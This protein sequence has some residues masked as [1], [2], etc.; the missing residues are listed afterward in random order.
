M[1]HD[2][3]AVTG[4]AGIVGT[5]V[6]QQLLRAGHTVHALVR[7][8]PPDGHPLLT[9]NVTLTMLDLATASEESMVNWL[10]TIRP[11]ALIHGAAWVDVGGCER[12]PSLASVLNTDVTR[13]FARACARHRTHFVMVSTDYVFDG[14][15]P[16]DQRYQENDPVHP[17]N[18]YGK[19]KMLG[20]IATQEECTDSTIW[21]ICRTAVVYGSARGS[22]SDFVQWLRAKLGHNEPVHIAADLIG[23]PTHAAD[24][25]KM[26]TAIVE[27]RLPGIYHT[28]GSTP[29][30]RYH[31]AL[32]IAQ[33]YDLDNTLIHSI[34]A[35]ELGSPLP[36]N[37]G[38]CVD[39]ISRD[40]GLRPLSVEQGLDYCWELEQVKG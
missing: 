18:Q 30:D 20:E 1:S 9:E 26:L 4:A 34:R 8:R 10:D 40:A 36:L 16:P 2:T 5:R 33:R 13:M 35:S 6:V 39:K 21:T 37:V 28:A 12:Q 3:V 31:F 27:H 29:M 24:L 11:S 25:A 17:I 7:S 14:T 15:Y 38:L 23:S 19:S 32:K 22:R